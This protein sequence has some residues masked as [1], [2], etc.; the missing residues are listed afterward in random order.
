MSFKSPN[1]ETYHQIE[2]GY[3]D[4]IFQKNTGI[5]SLWHRFKF[6]TLGELLRGISYQNLLDAGCGP[7][8]FISTLPADKTCVGVDLSPEQVAYAQEKFSAENKNFVVGDIFHLQQADESFD[9]I[10][11]I[12]LIEHLTQ[13]HI[14]LFFKEVYRCLK[15]GGHFLL[16]TPNYR[17]FWPLLEWIVSKVSPV[18][19]LDQHITKFNLKSLTTLLTQYGFQ[20]EQALTY[21][22]IAPFFAAFSDPLARQIHQIEKNYPLCPGNLL[23]LLGR[24]DD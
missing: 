23:C 5:Q 4:R 24:K 12:E 8:T 1:P 14:D 9:L 16:T 13:E 11:S 17:S 15:P 20:I 22:G 18:D 6:Q 19:Y 21:L 3:Y 2:R 7:G 10:T